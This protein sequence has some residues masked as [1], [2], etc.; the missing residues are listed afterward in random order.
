VRYLVY[1]TGAVGGLVGGRL[2]LSGH[3]VTF[4]ARP[5][6]AEAMQATRIHGLHGL[7]SGPLPANPSKLLASPLM[8]S[9]VGWLSRHYDMVLLDT[10][11]LLAVADTAVLASLVEGVV[12]VARRNHIREEAVREACR[13]LGDLKAPM[14]GLIVNEAERNGTYYYYQRKK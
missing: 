7:T 1:G 8:V 14:I 4:L 10:P 11:A 12:Y 2:A 3:P 9:I 13:Q 6:I 5:R